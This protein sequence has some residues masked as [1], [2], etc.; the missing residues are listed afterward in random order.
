[1]DFVYVISFELEG[2]VVARSGSGVFHPSDATF[3]L[4][5]MIWLMME[6]Y[7]RPLHV[8]V[9]MDFSPTLMLTKGSA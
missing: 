9:E 3:K 4:E 5:H 2:E 6:E 8:H 1:M 7:G